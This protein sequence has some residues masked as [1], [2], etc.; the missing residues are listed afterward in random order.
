MNVL[1]YDNE[2]QIGIAAGNYMCGQRHP[3]TISAFNFASR[4]CSAISKMVLM[5]SSFASLIKQ[6]VLMMMISA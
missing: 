6:Q 2:E 4:L 3:V 5:L 1:V